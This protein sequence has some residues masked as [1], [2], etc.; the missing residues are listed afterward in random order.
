MR[1]TS[2]TRVLI[3][4]DAYGHN[5]RF[6]RARIPKECEIAAVVKD[7]AY[8]HGLEPMAKAAVAQGCAMLGVATVEEGEA[9]RKA[10]IEAPILV[11]VQ[12]PESALGLA[13]EHGLR[14]MVS[15]VAIGERL[16]ELAHRANKVIPIHC[17]ID[18]G[19]GRQGFA[20]EDAPAQL[21]HLTRI[22]HIDIE[23]V[24]THF[25]VADTQEDPF[26]SQQVK[27]FKSVLKR[28]EKTGI[29]YE[30][31]HAANSAA[32]LNFPGS[33]FDMV[34][35]GL[36]TYGVWP[37]DEQPDGTPLKPVLRWE[38]KVV[39][40]KDLEPGSS[41]G[42]GRTYTTHSRMRAALLPIGYS[43]GYKH[44]LSNKADVIIRGKR[45]PV[46]GSVCMDQIMVD[47]SAMPDV[48]QGDW[49]TLIGV[50]GTEEIKV[51]ELARHARTI[52]YDILTGITPRIPREYVE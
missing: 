31:I 8:G 49:A 35:P 25:P 19:M 16:G 22:S 5:L 38:A 34:R 18:T 29:P 15:N 42:Y 37:T 50:D 14:V 45:C 27:V 23:G 32:L 1:N 12:P 20:V 17:K 36:M 30:I 41:V 21:L 44:A 28:L 6:V 10:G 7:D 48:V 4:L 40:V 3:D 11:L 51:A 43:H 52:P 13:V 9:L 39:L 24:A 46:R 33:V 26:T 2:A 47:V